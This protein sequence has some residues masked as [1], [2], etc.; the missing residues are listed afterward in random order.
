MK[1]LKTVFA[2]ALTGLLLTTAHAQTWLTNGLVA[3]YPFNGNA[4]DTSGNLNNGTVFGAASASDRFGLP[5][6][7]YY[8]NGTNQYISVPAASGL[9][10]A[11]K[12]TISMWIKDTSTNQ[13]ASMLGCWSEVNGGIYLND[14]TGVNFAVA[15]LPNGQI[16]HSDATLI[17]NW[18]HV[19]V[20][21]DGTQTGNGNRLSCYLNG[22]SNALTFPYSIPTSLGGG[23]S[24]ILI[25]ARQVFG[26]PGEFFTGLID[27]VRIYSR[28]LSSNEVVQ[29]NLIE[30]P[31]VLNIKKAVYLD[32]PNL[33]VGTNY[34]VQVSSN[35]LNWTN[36]GAIFTATNS[37]WRTTNYWDVE[38]WNQLYF[39]LQKQ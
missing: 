31:E 24:S 6:K 30:S 28:A 13:S 37:S 10:N 38:N 3:Y 9:N 34:Q 11:Q 36:S 15:I 22:V 39:R 21:F 2:T 18:N 12:T 27:D 23:A 14:Y 16:M 8:F 1:T 32:S 25:G 20:V 4:N 7:C 19:V 33:K 29:L 5:A 35:L 17:G 26:N